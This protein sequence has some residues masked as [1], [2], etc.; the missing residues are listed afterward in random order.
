MK[1]IFTLIVGA[2]LL[3]GLAGCDSDT[4]SDENSEETSEKPVDVFPEFSQAFTSVDTERSESYACSS[5]EYP[6]GTPL[7]H[8]FMQQLF[9]EVLLKQATYKETYDYY[10]LGTF[11]FTARQTGYLLG[12]YES[13]SFYS[14]HLFLYD[15]TRNAFTHTLSLNYFIGEGAFESKREAWLTDLNDDGVTDVMYRAMESYTPED[16]YY[17]GG[18]SRDTLYAQ[19]W[20]GD[21]FSPYSLEDYEGAKL[22][23]EI[24]IDTE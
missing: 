12:A 10:P 18:Y 19:V 14:S 15:S 17:E 24:P 9:G 16:E 23:F 22:A 6:N 13:E 1:S 21:V 20:D 3:A 4:K 8:S 2:L 7:D 11:P 5:M